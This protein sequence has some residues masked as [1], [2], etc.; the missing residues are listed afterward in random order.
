MY[1]RS[2]VRL[3][4]A[5]LSEPRRFIQIVTGP[6]Q[7]GKTTLTRQAIEAT[8]IPC[9]YASADDAGSAPHAW[10]AAQWDQG[11]QIAGGAGD[12]G[13]A[14]V[15]DEVQKVPLW[16]SEVKRLWDEDTAARCHLRV[17]LL[18]SSPL[19][20][21]AGLTESLAGR[22]EII[23]ATHWS[24]AE[25]R[26]AFGWDLDTYV[27]HG[28]YPGAVESITDWGR[29][30]RYVRDALVETS[31]SRDILMLTRVDKPALLRQLFFVGCAYSGQIVSY[32][33]LLGELHD[34]GNSTTVAHYLE[35]LHGAG[36]LT[37]LSKFTAAPDG[38][39]RSTPKLQVMDNAFRTAFLDSDGATARQ[40]GPLWGRLVESAVGAHLVN[41][42]FLDPLLRVGYWREAGD[43]VDFTLARGR[44]LLAIEVKSGAQARRLRGLQRFQMRFPHARSLLVGADGVSLQEFLLAPPER[45]LD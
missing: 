37:G 4:E 27:L 3:L 1:Q 35:L 40:D 24:Y 11:R 38:R 34:A 23:P 14:L 31:L 15:L 16:S 26:E 12:E 7:V 5:R 25:M 21:Q 29:W 30:A 13:A 20:L 18:G 36:M 33:K 19:L 22:F 43:E 2:Q 42:T 45:W 6:R 32:T 28:G 39:R 44:K 41:A 8:P 10:I 9:H 17:V